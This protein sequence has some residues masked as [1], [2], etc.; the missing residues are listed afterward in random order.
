MDAFCHNS[1]QPIPRVEYTEQEIKT[2]GTIFR[3]LTKLYPTHACAE[4]NHVFP[5]L[6][7]NCSYRE[8]TIPQLDDI[9]RFLKGASNI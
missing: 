4:F 8:D 7:E 5:L 9:S 6:I 3:E 2:W 1:G